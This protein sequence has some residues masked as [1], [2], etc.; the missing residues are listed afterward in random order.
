M[1]IYDLLAIVLIGMS[2]VL[3]FL[4]LIRY[5]R[6]SNGMVVGLS[7]VF[8]ILLSL[9]VT[10]TGYP[11]FNVILL[12]LFLLSLGLLKDELTFGKNLYFSLVSMVCITLVKM[13]L[14]ELGMWLFML[15]PFNLY[16][17]T[18]SVIHLIVSLV[19]II[20]IILLKKP[21]GNFAQFIVESPL[22]YFSYA[23]LV[24]GLLLELILTSPSTHLLAS[25][26]EQYGNISYIAAFV[27]FFLLLLIVLISSHMTKERILEEREQRLDKEFLDYVKKLEQLHDDLAS[28]RHD[29]MNILLSLN[30]GVRTKNMDQ[31]EQVYNDVIA[32][33]SQLM[34]HHELDVVKLSHILIPEVKSL[35]GVKLM[36]AQ[37]QQIKVTVD[38]PEKIEKI[39]MPTLPF[40][41]AASILVDNAMEETVR[42][43]DKM[44]Q[45]AFFEIENCQYF[46][47]R[48]SCDRESIDLQRIYEK[49]YS[50]KKGNLVVI[51]PMYVPQDSVL[52]VVEVTVAMFALTLFVYSLWIKRKGVLQ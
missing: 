28:F 25:L 50:D 51:L 37:Q 45:L 32:P 27:L 22:Y 20:S 4:Y 3:F 23:L 33:T 29:Y 31:I 42:S 5:S 48:N 17:W 52:I 41:R 11:E 43:K 15:T 38:I 44:L 7:I 16:I 2:H 26:Y 8:T 1:F 9:I 49:R 6:F 19:I 30:E 40:I 12:L 10:V 24:V 34:N 36:T 46:I 39:S 35:L 14:M 18:S 21:I 47:V 13:V